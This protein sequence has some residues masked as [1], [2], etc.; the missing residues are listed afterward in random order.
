MK[1]VLIVGGGTAGWMSAAFL[2]KKGFNVTLIESKTIPIIG[3]GESTLPAMTTFCKELGLADSDWMDKVQAVHKLGICHKGW[4]KNSN[5][6]WWHWF[7][8]DRR[9]QESKHEYIKQNKIPESIFE[10]AYH[11]DAI[12]FGNDVCKPVAIKNNCNH[13]IDDVIL[14]NSSSDGITDIVT[15]EHGKLTADF[16]IDCSGFSRVLAKQIGIRYKSFDHVIN[17]SAIA[18]PQEPL[19]QI[20][21]FTITR[22]MNCGWN[23]EIALQHRRGAGYVYSSKF[24]NDDDAIKEYIN[25]YPATDRNKLRVLK[26]K[27][28]YSENPIH[29]NCITIGLS[30]G[31]L[32]PLEATSIWLIQY[33]VEGFYRTITENLD[34]KIFNKAQSKIMNE[35]HDFILCH[36]TLSDH[37]DTGYWG[38]YK[39]LEKQLNTKRFVRS[40]SLEEDSDPKKY[41]KMFHT[42]SWWSMNK[43]LN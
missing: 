28:E 6:D 12:R 32:E 9:N 31:F 35:I 2:S 42:Y 15:K 11:I 3:V 14:V 10:Y 27:S 39:D 13:I 17:D 41:T 20:N 40:K 21:R 33:F 22:K 38:Y 8:Y 25:L 37:D 30:S 43:F 36:Y 7:E 29:K 26:F 4:K 24:I 18:C 19:E 16:Y 1:K 23:W 5:T 34:P